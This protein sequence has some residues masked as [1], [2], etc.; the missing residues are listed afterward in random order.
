MRRTTLAL[1]ENLLH[2]LKERSARERRTLQALANDLLRQAMARHQAPL[3]YSLELDGWH[4]RTR[5]GVDLLD[6]DKLFD[7]MGG[8]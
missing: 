3:D 7:L 4:A 8:R 6:R 2:Q 5:P 1:E